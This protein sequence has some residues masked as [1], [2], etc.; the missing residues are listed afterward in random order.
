VGAGRLL[1]AYLLWR[2]PRWL[3]WVRRAIRQEAPLPEIVEQPVAEAAPLPDDVPTAVSA[4][5]REG[6][7]RDALALLYRASVARL[8]ARL[9]TPF[10]PGATE[11]DCLRRARRLEDVEARSSFNEV[12][13]TW[14]RAAY[15]R[16]FPE[17]E[18]FAALLSTWSQ[19]F[20]C[21]HEARVLAARRRPARDTGRDRL[22]AV[23][24]ACSRK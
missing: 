11:A 24:D 10:P 22:G 3:P 14:Q 1:V 15:A 20:R 16:Q 6:R 23:P 9:D 17:S 21:R 5:W 13:R 12:V 19:R 2:L 7:Q 18:A 8:S 4:L